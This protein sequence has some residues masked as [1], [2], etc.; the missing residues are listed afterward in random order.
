MLANLLAATWGNVM[1]QGSIRARLADAVARAGARDVT[2][3]LSHNDETMPLCDAL[4]L[5]E[6]CG[7]DTA[8]LLG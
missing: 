3:V 5:A 7:M 2:N 6:V 4:R 8:E 1:T